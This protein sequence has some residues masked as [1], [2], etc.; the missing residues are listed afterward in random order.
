LPLKRLSIPPIELLPLFDEE[1]ASS[2]SP[3]TCRGGRARS[4]EVVCAVIYSHYGKIEL[5]STAGVRTEEESLT[6]TVF[7]ESLRQMNEALGK[8]GLSPVTGLVS[9][10]PSRL[11]FCL[12]ILN[13]NV[14]R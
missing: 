4:A 11:F 14:C 13:S 6:V 1:K 5:A 8:R 9:R 2:E 10:G 3:S 7:A 12:N